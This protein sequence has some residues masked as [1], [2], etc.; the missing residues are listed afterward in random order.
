MSIEE[1]LN[2]IKE[3]IFDG[4][5]DGAKMAM[6][7]AVDDD[8]DPAMILSDAI[9]PAIKDIGVSM[10]EGDFFMPEVKMSTKALQGVAEILRPHAIP[11]KDMASYNAP[12]WIGEGLSLIHI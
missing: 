9:M 1:R 7:Q 6:K 8:V 3:A 4:E 10:Q 12:P 5:L 2:A 11:E